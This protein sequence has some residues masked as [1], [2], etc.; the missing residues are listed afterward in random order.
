MLANNKE[1]LII[2][3]GGL[4][5]NKKGVW[6]TDSFE[7]GGGDSNGL[8]HS[9]WRI[10][11]AKLLFKDDDDQIIIASGGKGQFKNIPNAP[12]VSSVIKSEL[13]E[14]GISPKSIVEEDKSNN[15]LEQLNYLAKIV[16]DS[17]P[18]RI[19]IISNEW[20]LERIRTFIQ[21]DKNLSKTFNGF[22]AILVSA[23]NILISQERDKWKKSIELARASK[24]IKRRIGLEKQGVKD[25]KNGVYGKNRNNKL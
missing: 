12:T 5:K 11:A 1:F 21:T 16:S 14:S 25:I 19:T 22:K 20:A 3:G 4:L 10:E 23:E 24:N 6:Q 17:K 13:V 9:R 8:T 7:E 18:A 15:T 2:F